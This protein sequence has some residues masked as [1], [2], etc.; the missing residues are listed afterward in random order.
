MQIRRANFDDEAALLDLIKDH[1]SPAFSWP[2]DQFISEFQTTQTWVLLKGDQIE[3][4]ICVRDAV[5][6]W[7]LSV[8]ATRQNSVGQGY[9]KTLLNAVIS[10]YGSQRQLWL[11]VHEQNLAARKLYEK[12]GFE[13]QGRRPVYYRDGAAAILYTRPQGKV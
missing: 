1:Q 3:A 11:E 10:E 6:A 2:R 8:L 12:C 4:F 9:M 5:D 7:E 13:S